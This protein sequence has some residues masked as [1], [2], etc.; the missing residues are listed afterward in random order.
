MSKFNLGNGP[1]QLHDFIGI[2]LLDI[3][4]PWFIRWDLSQGL[5]PQ[6]EQ[7]EMFTS[8]HFF[9]HMTTE[10]GIRLMRLCK[11][12]LKEGGVF[13]LGV[14]DF[15]DMVTNYLTGNW[16]HWDVIS[17]DL[18]RYSNPATRTILDICQEGV[19]QYDPNPANTHKSLWDVEK[20]LKILNYV[21]LKDVKQV[22]Y[23]FAI[24][25]PWE[26]RRRYTLIAEGTK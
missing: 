19:Y 7:A 23:D 5:P 9:E 25:P 14:P 22:P 3:N 20:A 16:D 1:T 26:M 2:D 24:D 15:R 6:A 12:N 11:D 10:D 4:A 18:D 8:C 21:G 13:R 17:S